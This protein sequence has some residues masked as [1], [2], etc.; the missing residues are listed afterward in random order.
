[1]PLVASRIKRLTLDSDGTIDEGSI[2]VQS[3]YVSNATL[4]AAEVVFTDKDGTPVLNMLVSACDS[5][6]F[7]GT[8]IAD[9]GLKVLGLSGEGSANV[10]VTVLHTSAGA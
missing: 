5:E 4:S 9:N 3:I 1:M 2:R 6:Q 8:W 7:P 10:V